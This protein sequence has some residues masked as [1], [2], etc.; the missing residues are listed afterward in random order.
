MTPPGKTLN[1]ACDHSAAKLGPEFRS[2]RLV[3]IVALTLGLM[4]SGCAWMPFFGSPPNEC[5]FERTGDVY[6][7][8]V[9]YWVIDEMCRQAGVVVPEDRRC[10]AYAQVKRPNEPC[11][12]VLPLVGSGGVTEA[13]YQDLKLH[14]LGHCNGW[15]H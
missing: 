7:A 1:P 14:E 5:S 3:T 6:V 15:R 10:D 9:D 8:E 11:I 12:M 13:Q 2:S 4:T